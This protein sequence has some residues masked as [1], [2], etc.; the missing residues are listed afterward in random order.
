[1]ELHIPELL[2]SF[3]TGAG[4]VTV[5]SAMGLIWIGAALDIIL[6]G[7]CLWKLRSARAGVSSVDAVSPHDLRSL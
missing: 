7:L 5:A 4:I 3:N 1:M 2:F 6:H